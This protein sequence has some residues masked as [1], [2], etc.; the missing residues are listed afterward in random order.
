MIIWNPIGLL[1]FLKYTLE[2]KI[3]NS[4]NSTD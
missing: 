3:S 4:E 2:E 1:W